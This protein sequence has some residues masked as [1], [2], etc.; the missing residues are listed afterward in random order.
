[1]SV[2]A[3][4]RVREANRLIEAYVK[5]EPRLRFIDVFSVMV[6]ASGKPRAELYIEDQ[7][8]PSSAA[9]ALWIPRIEP[10]LREP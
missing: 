9:Y 7:L 2:I 10:F 1:M 5:T 3:S 8:H 6:D 4:E